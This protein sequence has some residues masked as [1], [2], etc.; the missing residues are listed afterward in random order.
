MTGPGDPPEG[1]PE[2]APGGGEDEYRSV[3]FDESFVRAARLQEFSAQERMG[4]HARAVRSRH[5]W[6]R[7]GGS[8]QAVILVLLI[9]LAFGTAIYMGVRHPYRAPEPTPAPPL[10]STVVPLAPVGTVPGGRPAD[11]FDRSPAAGFRIGA[12]GVNL[13][14]VRRTGE[15]SDSQVMTALTTAKEY[16]V[17]S[18]LDSDTLSGGPAR[19]VRLLLDTSQLDQFDRSLRRPSDDGR[20]AATGWLVR[21]DPSQ[22]RLADPRVRVNGTLAV[23]SAAAGNA[24]EVTAD[25]TFVYAM[26]PPDGRPAAG[27]P[28]NTAPAA[29]ERPAG[30][31]T[32][33]TASAVSTSAS[34]ASAVGGKV[35]SAAAQQRADGASLFTVRR[36]LHFRFDR[37]D[38]RDRRLEVQSSYLQAGPMSCSSGPESALRPLLA[39]ERAG[40]GRPQGTDPYAHGST[41]ASLCG[42][43]APS[44]EPSPLP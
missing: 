20:H 35:Q 12:A 2:G 23:E 8:R 14:V 13:P 29:A 32:G 41:N 10:R 11:L 42:V 6:S 22:A 1:T 9:A 18:S 16:V 37:D 40:N 33:S 44:A 38:L 43:M 28:G 36:E 4:D 27:G 15:F 21:F 26:R 19:G 25:Y 7:F 34:T 31:A 30:S 24:L 3:V 17:R 39:G 5:A